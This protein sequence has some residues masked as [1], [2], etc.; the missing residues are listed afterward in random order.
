MEYGLITIHS[1]QNFGSLLQTFSTISAIRSL[2]ISITLIDYHNEK[3]DERETAIFSGNKK[4][5][6]DVIKKYYGEKIK[7]ENIIVS[8]TF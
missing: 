4:S 5:L 3:I 6:K 7:S 2:G 8:I 1:T